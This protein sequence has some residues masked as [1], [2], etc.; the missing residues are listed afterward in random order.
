MR[1]AGT[2][3]TFPLHADIAN[4]RTKDVQP[5]SHEDRQSRKRHSQDQDAHGHSKRHRASS[6]PRH[7]SGDRTKE[8]GRHREHRSSHSRHSRGDREPHSKDEADGRPRAQ[9][10]PNASQPAASAPANAV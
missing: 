3:F 7:D 10:P 1:F 4:G 2:Q 9:T 8:G 6:R 5:S